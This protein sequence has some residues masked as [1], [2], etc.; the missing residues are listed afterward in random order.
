MNF[1]KELMVI[2]EGTKPKKKNKKDK[3]AD[4]YDTYVSGN[5]LFRNTCSSSLAGTKKISND[6]RQ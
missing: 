2:N 5:M 3:S 1:L 4:K 6:L